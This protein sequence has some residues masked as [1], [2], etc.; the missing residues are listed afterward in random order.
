MGRRA[1]PTAFAPGADP[2]AGTEPAPTLRV[3][4][5]GGLTTSS[6]SITS[7]NG[8]ALCFTIG[9]ASAGGFDIKVLRGKDQAFQ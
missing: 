1:R 9:C 5:Q 8:D 6:T 3:R 2:F 4:V 7:K